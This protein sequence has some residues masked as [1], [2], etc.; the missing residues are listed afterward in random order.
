[1]REFVNYEHRINDS[2]NPV[3]T[4]VAILKVM[5]GHYFFNLRGTTGEEVERLAY[6]Q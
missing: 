6:R 3:P 2:G 4:N 5:N 1:M